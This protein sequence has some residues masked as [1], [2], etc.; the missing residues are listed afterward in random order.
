MIKTEFLRLFFYIYL[1]KYIKARY[2]NNKIVTDCIVWD[3]NLIT[4]HNFELKFKKSVYFGKVEEKCDYSWR[5]MGYDVIPPFP[6]YLYYLEGKPICRDNDK[7]YI[8]EENGNCNGKY[9]DYD[10]LLIKNKSE[11][12]CNDNSDYYMRNLKKKYKKYISEDKK[13][14]FKQVTNYSMD[15]LFNE[16]YFSDTCFLKQVLS[17]DRFVK[18]NLNKKGLHIFRIILAEA[19]YHNIMY[20]KFNGYVPVVFKNWLED[21]YLILDYDKEKYYLEEILKN[22]TFNKIPKNLPFVEKSIK[23]IKND[24]QYIF[25]VDT[26]HSIVKMWIYDKD[27]KLENGPLNFIKGSNKN[28]FK[29]LKYLYKETYDNSYNVIKEPSVR[30]KNNNVYDPSLYLPILPL[31]NTEKTLIIA[32]TSGFHC[33]GFAKEGT[34]RKYLRPNWDNNDGGLHRINFFIN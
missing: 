34:I 19:I 23:H 11:D 9:G 18:S 31:N 20:N 27:I 4:F 30:L 13:K 17:K 5:H 10:V 15:N 21:G 24:H 25:H 32:D 29:K 33:R 16:L 3:N 7:L 14:L 12:K 26:F 1:A 2:F 6:P 8:L 22:I 28:D